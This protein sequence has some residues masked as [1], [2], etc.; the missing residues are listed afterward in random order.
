MML[1]YRRLSMSALSSHLYDVGA[2][3]R[4]TTNNRDYSVVVGNIWD[5]FVI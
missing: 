3:V 2:S 1:D 5:F 4:H